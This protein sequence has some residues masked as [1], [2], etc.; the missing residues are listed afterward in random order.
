MLSIFYWRHFQI[1]NFSNPVFIFDCGV[2]AAAQS[3]ATVLFF[4]MLFFYKELVGL[5]HFTL[6][7]FTRNINPVSASHLSDWMLLVSRAPVRVSLQYLFIYIYL[8]LIF[9]YRHRRLEFL[10]LVFCCPIDSRVSSTP[11][12]GLR[13]FFF[14]TINISLY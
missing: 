5:E 12:Y 13:S 3:N 7:V 4:L 8:K 1:W 2:F 14:N 11:V 6:L 10:L 9:S